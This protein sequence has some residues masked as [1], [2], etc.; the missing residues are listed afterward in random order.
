MAKIE[1]RKVGYPD[2]V[3]NVKHNQGTTPVSKNIQTPPKKPKR[4]IGKIEY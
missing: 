3:Q 4:Y 1:K 2:N